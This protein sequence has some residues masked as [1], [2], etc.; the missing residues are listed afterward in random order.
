[1]KKIWR[2]H[3]TTAGGKRSGEGGMGDLLSMA[4]DSFES[5]LAGFGIGLPIS[6]AYAEYLGG[7][8]EIKTMSGIGTDVYLTLK[9]IDPH[10]GHSF[11]IWMCSFYN[12][13]N[14]SAK[15][16]VAEKKCIDC[17]RKKSNFKTP[18]KLDN[19]F[20]FDQKLRWRVIFFRVW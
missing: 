8:L 7:S 2:Y 13:K 15:T 20:T 16:G 17:I 14:S 18:D 5:E 3:F 1:M 11:R 19:F 12:L 6:K 9:H 10:H 4:N